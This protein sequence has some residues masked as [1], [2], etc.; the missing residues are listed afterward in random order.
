[1]L[2][3]LKIENVA[4]I[5][6]AEI[7]FENGLNIMTGETGAGKSIV[8][9]SINAVLGERTSKDLVR[10]GTTSAKITAC[11]E[12]VSMSVKNALELMEIDCESDG[13]LIVSRTI[14][15]DGRSSCRVNG[16]PV[17][18]SM[19]RTLGRELVTIC[20]QHDSQHLLQK[21]THIEYIDFLADIG[22]ILSEYRNVYSSVVKKKKELN[23]FLKSLKD[24]EE[25]R[26]YLSFRIKEIEQAKIVP[27]EK[28]KLLEDRK[29]LQNRE[30]LAKALYG[31]G[32]ALNGD[33][34]TPG[35]TQNLYTLRAFLNQLGEYNSEFEKYAKGIE[36]L[37]Y[38]L[39]ECSSTVSSEV[40]ALE[41]EEL[42]VNYIEERLDVL[43]RLS[44]KYGETE[45]EILGMLEEYKA[46]LDALEISDEKIAELENEVYFLSENLF[47]LAEEISDRR[48]KAALDFENDVVAEL[49]Y[50][51]MPSA[52][53]KVSF[54]QTAATSKGIDD[55]EFLIS[56]N[57]G[58]EPKPLSKIASGGELSRI[59]LAIKC[60]L[61]DLETADTM[62]FDEIDTGVS[63]RAAHKIAYKLKRV[64]EKR[65]AVCVTHLA[66]IAAASDN[67]LF[68]E[69]LTEDGRAYTKVRKLVDDERI[70][71]IARIIGGDVITKS[72]V[73]SACELIDF[74]NTP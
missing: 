13:T 54:T 17:T 55:V 28:E 67:H 42:D 2:S 34:N 32:V 12:D 63:G 62:I 56:A 50:L 4:V 74:A 20:G 37:S 25:R 33:D 15:A 44:K 29:K 41:G 53:F 16:Q 47:D 64:S 57:K 10:S 8:I 73:M 27:G 21:E 11:F 40:S 72:T 51:D 22:E 43:Y 69:K 26:E 23:V 59:M 36:K 48:R 7:N 38:I 66:Q 3:E 71:E 52:V 19:L 61:S 9:D 70:Y 24:K 1:M 30:K 18:V 45:E 6:K 5:E 46:E 14:S 58:Q 49:N 31:A 60:V 68:I 39:E 35:C 65:Q